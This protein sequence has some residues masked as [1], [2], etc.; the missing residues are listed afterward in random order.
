ME[1]TSLTAARAWVKGELESATAFW[2]SHGRDRQNGGIYTCLDRKGALYSTDKSVWM[3]GRCAWTYAYLCSV[4]GVRDEWLSF[5][6]SCLDFMEAHCINRELGGRM[7]FTVTADGRP[8]RQRRYCFSEGFYAIANAEYYGVTGEER[9][10]KRALQAYELI[11]G[12][13]HGEA[14]PTG[15]GSKTIAET[16]MGRALANPMIYLNI[17]DVLRRVNPENETLYADRAAE[18]VNE[19]RTYHYKPSLGCT[20]ETVGSNG[21]YLGDITDGRFVN[22][23]HD[24][25]C[26]WFLLEQARRT[27]D[28]ETAKLAQSIYDQAFQTGWDHTYGGLLYFVDCEG[29]PP[30]AYEHDMKLWWPHAEIL[31]ASL[32]LYRSTGDKTYLEHF[33]RTLAYCKAVFSDPMYGE[34]FGYCRRDGK[35]TEP[36]CKGST[37]KGPFHVQRSLILSDRLLG[38]ILEQE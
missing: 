30:Q 22:P 16:R 3:Q 32:S 15:L 33:E 20:L 28:D 4:Y 19:I 25:E 24:I 35:P 2:I 11:Y 18:C 34:W 31:I 10:L 7:Y 8:L 37:F 1:H 38:E 21:E 12:L 23:G 36:P 9:Y 13:N 29:K 6:K 14:D 5:S 17:T 26:S 27:G